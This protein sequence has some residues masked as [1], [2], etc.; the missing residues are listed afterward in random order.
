MAFNTITAAPADPNQL[1]GYTAENSQ[2]ERQWEQMF[3]AIPD[4]K[5]VREYDQRL[6]A[7]PHHVGSPYDKDNAEWM[8]NTFKEWG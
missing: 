8:M 1:T 6:S 5:K 4:P 7:R 2:A 3:R